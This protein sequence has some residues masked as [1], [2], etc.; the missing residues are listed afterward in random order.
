MP[1]LSPTKTRWFFDSK[2][3]SRGLRRD[4]AEVDQPLIDLRDVSLK[5]INY[6]DKTYTIKR[7]FLQ[8]ILRRD[9]PVPD[10]E[11]W[12]LRNISLRIRRG[13]RIGVLGSNGAGKSTLLR[14]LAR[15]YPPTTGEVA[16]RGTVAPLIEMGAGFNPELTGFDNILLNGAML[17]FTR[18]QML[19]KVDEIHEFTGLREFA[20]LPLKYYSSGM[21]A[22]LAF[23]V[24]T[25][26]DPEILLVDESLGVGDATFRR[27]ATQ[28][29]RDLMGRSHA[30]I[31]VSHDMNSLRELCD[32]GLW[33]RGGE[34]VADGP[35]D[36]VVDDYEEWT[37]AA[38][39]A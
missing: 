38:K 12:A 19:A 14:L 20:D 16:V 11:F 39:P 35:I 9:K 32:R 34:L 27:K 2:G 36:Q 15:I 26:I 5:F 8:L 21:Y 6:A 29:I 10:S 24:A 7:A 18:K 13:E 37:K 17:G 28:R 22:R 3:R 31:L 1:R 30:V 33:I 25:S 4:L 23:G